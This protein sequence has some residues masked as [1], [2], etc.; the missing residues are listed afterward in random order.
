MILDGSRMTGGNGVQRRVSHSRREILPE[1]ADASA[2][3]VQKDRK[4]LP[5]TYGKAIGELFGIVPGRTL[6]D[7]PT[8]HVTRVIPVIVVQDQ[9]LLLSG[10]Q[11]VAESAV[12]T[13]DALLRIDAQA[14]P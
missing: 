11:L 7:I 4:G 13:D 10:H 2:G 14:S 8:G 9:A 1:H 12:S 6:Q 5:S 3:S